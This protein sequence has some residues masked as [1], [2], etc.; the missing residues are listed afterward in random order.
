MEQSYF[1]SRVLA[2]YKHCRLRGCLMLLWLAGCRRRT[3]CRQPPHTPPL[4][5]KCIVLAFLLII[6]STE[7]SSWG[8]LRLPLDMS[9][10]TIVC[11]VWIHPK[12]ARYSDFSEDTDVQCGVLGLSYSLLVVFCKKKKKKSCHGLRWGVWTIIKKEIYPNVLKVQESHQLSLQ[13]Q[14]INRGWGTKKPLWQV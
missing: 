5:S 3:E 10:Q 7:S 13:L 6:L 2:P 9:K 11:R 12:N 8:K 1:W 14:R 4:K